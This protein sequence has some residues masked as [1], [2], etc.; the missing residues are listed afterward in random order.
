M[1]LSAQPTPG[2]WQSVKKSHP[3]AS[4]SQHGVRGLQKCSA[5]THVSDMLEAMT[6]PWALHSQARPDFTFASTLSP[7]LIP[8]QGLPPSQGGSIKSLYAKQKQYQVIPDRKSRTPLSTG[9][10]A[11]SD[12]T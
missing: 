4:G 6:R 8:T 2:S 11:G 7:S 5:N 3:Q 1:A 12:S 10:T 9:V